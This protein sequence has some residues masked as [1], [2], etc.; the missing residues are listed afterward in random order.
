[1]CAMFPSEGGVPVMRNCQISVLGEAAPPEN[2][3]RCAP[4]P[5]APAQVYPVPV[6]SQPVALNPPFC[7]VHVP[8]GLD[9]K[10]AAVKEPWLSG[11]IA[12]ALM[13][14]TTLPV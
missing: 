11:M 9:T 7:K 14:L 3:N 4:V 13:E 5:I 8:R 10:L 12:K 1:M 6:P 2:E